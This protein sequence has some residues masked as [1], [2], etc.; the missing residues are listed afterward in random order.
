MKEI[1]RNH[2]RCRV[3]LKCMAMLAVNEKAF[4]GIKNILEDFGKEFTRK[5]TTIITF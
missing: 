4:I 1:I 2:I 3:W 5:T